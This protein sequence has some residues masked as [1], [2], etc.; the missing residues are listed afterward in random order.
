MDIALWILQILLALTFVG[1]GVSHAFRFD[2]FAAR[3]RMAWAT[4]VGRERM[5]LIGLAEIAG[6]I[7]L[8]VPAVTG[9]L[10]WLTPLAAAGLVLVML[11]AAAFHARRRGEVSNVAINLVIGALA[12]LVVVGRAFIQ[13]AT[14]ILS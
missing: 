1:A 6:G 14:P 10:P 5:R 12:L 3:P 8:I 4:D 7:G 13:P 11:A 2:Q 9:I